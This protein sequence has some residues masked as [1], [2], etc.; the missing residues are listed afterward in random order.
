MAAFAPPTHSWPRR[1][2]VRTAGS[3]VWLTRPFH[4]VPTIAGWS[5][6]RRSFLPTRRRSI[7]PSPITE[8]ASNRVTRRAITPAT[9]STPPSSQRLPRPTIRAVCGGRRPSGTR[10]RRWGA[11]A[12][13]LTARPP[14]TAPR[15]RCLR[16][17][18]TLVG[19]EATRSGRR[20]HRPSITI[21]RH[22]SST[23]QHVSQ[24]SAGVRLSKAR[25]RCSRARRRKRH[26]KCRATHCSVQR[27]MDILRTSTVLYCSKRRR[28]TVMDS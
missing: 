3:A 10:A 25:A 6:R 14:R 28:M 23:P 20:W 16:G 4:A 5:P 13:A 15:A 18:P 7:C 21:A 22:C 2:L 19:S 11:R 12:A 8:R 26:L 17:G 24:P 1:S 27:C 9:P